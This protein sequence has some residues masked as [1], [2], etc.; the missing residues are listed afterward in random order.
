MNDE[1]LIAEADN[2]KH[3]L[4]NSHPLTEAHIDFANTVFGRIA[5]ELRE[6]NGIIK[7]E[8]KTAKIINLFSNS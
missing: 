6:R 2:A 5:D 4:E 7:P 8:K 3:I 1:Q